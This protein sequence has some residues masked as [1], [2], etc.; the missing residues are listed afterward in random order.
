MKALE[1]H[2]K[3]EGHFRLAAEFLANAKRSLQQGDVRSCADRA[4]F[5]MYHATEAAL[6]KHGIYTVSHVGQIHFFKKSFVEKGL[7]EPS[8]GAYLEKGFIL[9]Q[10]C[11]EEPCYDADL[12]EVHEL[13]EK[14]QEFTAKL[15]EILGAK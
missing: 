14:A 5:A 8:L 3:V 4:F 13:V 1:T 12:K 15:K 9:Q 11:S 6:T 2:Q 7:M 10:L